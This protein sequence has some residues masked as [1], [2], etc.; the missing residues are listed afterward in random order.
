MGHGNE[1]LVQLGVRAA[2]KT[3]IRALGELGVTFIEALS[4]PSWAKEHS[5]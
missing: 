5:T 2:P 3:D 1:E 4:F